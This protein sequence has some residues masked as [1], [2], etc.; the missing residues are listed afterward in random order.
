MKLILLT[1]CKVFYQHILQ[2][3]LSCTI[4]KLHDFI[5]FCYVLS[6]QYAQL[7]CLM[8]M[9]QIYDFIWVIKT[10]GSVSCGPRNPG[11]VTD[12]C[13]FYRSKENAVF[14]H[15]QQWRNQTFA[16]AREKV[17]QATYSCSTHTHY[18]HQYS[19]QNMLQLL[20]ILYVTGGPS[21]AKSV[22]EI[23]KFTHQ[24]SNFC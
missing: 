21:L 4:S 6:C 13:V 24:I 2:Q 3:L 14:M 12:K 19:F 16:D 1:T 7:F 10:H 15:L 8:L 17:G 20:A 23:S 18:G 9:Q 22:D 11:R 5:R